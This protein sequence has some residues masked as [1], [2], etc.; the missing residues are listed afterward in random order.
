MNVLEEVA[1]RAPACGTEE[2]GRSSLSC[3]LK[4]QHSSVK[5][6]A[7]DCR[8]GVARPACAVSLA[9]I[10]ALFTICSAGG[11]LGENPISRCNTPLNFVLCSPVQLL[12][13]SLSEFICD[14]LRILSSL[15]S[16]TIYAFNV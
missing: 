8:L 10:L 5:G 16:L 6:L 2:N 12:E 1:V 13:R 15:S 4:V 7:A 3:H 11:R 14:G 9:G